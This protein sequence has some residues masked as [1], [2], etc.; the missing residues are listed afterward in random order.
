M[1]NKRE[2]K[3][4]FVIIFCNCAVSLDLLFHRLLVPAEQAHVT[5]EKDP[6]DGS[7]IQ[8]PNKHDPGGSKQAS[9][10]GDDTTATT[11]AL[12]GTCNIQKD[13]SRYKKQ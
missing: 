6:T 8:W 2:L 5:V 7:Q 4:T 13:T 12:D 9:D 11:T 1:E 10:D 3:K